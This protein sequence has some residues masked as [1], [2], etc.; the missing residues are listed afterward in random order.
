MA[1][2]NEDELVDY[3]EEEEVAVGD[4]ATAGEEA[5][6]TKKGHYVGIHAS[7][8][9][10]FLLKPE[11]LRAI[12]DAGFEHPSEVQH[13]TIPQAVLGG[14]IICQAKSGMGKTAVFTLATL[15]QANVEEAKVS[16][17]VIC[18]T[19]E[20]AFQIAHE[21]E[22]FSKYL[23][24]VKTAVFYG[25]VPVKQNLEILKNDCPHIVVGTPGRILAL[26]RD[27]AL[28]LGNIKHFVLD[29]C[30]RVLESLDMRRDIQ[31]IFRLTPHEKQVML[32][33]ATLA[34][35]V[36][37]VCKKFFDVAWLALYY[38][39][40]AEAEKNRKLNDLLD[41]L[42]FNQVV[43]FVSKVARA[44]ELNRLLTE[45]NFPSICIHGGMKQEERIKQYKSFKDFNARILVATDLFGRGIDIERVNVVIN[46]D[47]PDESDQFLHR[48]GRAGRFGTKGI[49]ISF[50]SSEGD[51][52][53]LSKV[54]SR[55][56]V[57]IPELPD[58]IDMSTYMST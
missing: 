27:K 25:G 44:K 26:A 31:E 58:E 10:D 5:K 17:L 11:L 28:N 14:D 35:E 41:A 9:K 36:R 39:K 54:Q 32:F 50:I 8:F 6:E 46:Y 49:A 43:I 57:N 16:V 30:D 56:E 55:F 29:E 38:S 12:V 18:H 22:R 34:K 52:E 48:V 13:E 47:F 42:E 3:D 33:S 21:Y 20:L 24:S 2:E 7:G 40:L 19:R 53:I 37:P 45:C 4:K 23:P 1:T 51:Q 15:Q